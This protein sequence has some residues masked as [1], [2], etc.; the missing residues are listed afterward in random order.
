MDRLGTL[1]AQ[2]T[3]PSSG[4]SGHARNLS[5][6]GTS[7]SQSHLF[8]MAVAA[9]LLARSL[10][11]ARRDPFCGAYRALWGP[12]SLAPCHKEN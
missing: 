7:R 8:G 9:R 5:A 6:R 12:T 4:R 1:S 3:A 11:S 2:I 10:P